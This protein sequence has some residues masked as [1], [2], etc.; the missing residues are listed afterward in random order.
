VELKSVL[1]SNTLKALKI[2][3]NKSQEA[4]GSFQGG[5]IIKASGRLD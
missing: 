3:F 5:E 4:E 2:Q 1:Y